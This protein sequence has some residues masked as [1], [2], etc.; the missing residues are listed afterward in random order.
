MG[1]G[2]NCITLYGSYRVEYPLS[3]IYEVL[4]ISLIDQIL[5]GLELFIEN[6][7]RGLKVL[8]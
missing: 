1:W 3:C 2:I 4:S 7:P 8:L 5:L 6:I